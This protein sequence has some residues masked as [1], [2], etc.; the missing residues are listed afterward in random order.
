MQHVESIASKR[1]C[2]LVK[3][4]HDVWVNLPHTDQCRQAFFKAEDGLTC[5]LCD[6]ALDYDVE[7]L[8]SHIDSWE[9]VQKI[10]DTHLNGIP[11]DTSRG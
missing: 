2:N 8:K 9:H 10:M 3:K 5:I 7:E 4:F 11:R 6:K 1:R